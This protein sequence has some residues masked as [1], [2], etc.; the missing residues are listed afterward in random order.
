[1]LAISVLTPSV[2]ALSVLALSVLALSVLAPSVLAPSVLAP[3]VLAPSVL[4]PS[5]FAPGKRA[6]PGLADR[7]RRVRAPASSSEAGPAPSSVSSPARFFTHLCCKD[8]QVVALQRSAR[9]GSLQKTVRA[10][11]EDRAWRE[12][13]LDR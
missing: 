9:M 7:D 8:T 1:M 5:V 4:A 2:L 10:D 6:C 11:R 12:R 3:S 13:R